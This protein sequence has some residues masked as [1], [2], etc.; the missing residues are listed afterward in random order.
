M[1]LAHEKR[2]VIF[3][4]AESYVKEYRR[5]ER[6]EICLKR[7]ARHHGSFYVPAEPKVAIVVRIRGYVLQSVS[8]TLYI[9]KDI[10]I[11]IT[12]CDF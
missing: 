8:M 6:D 1:Q 11:Y 9:F 5:K 10:L 4:R 2:R 3:K 7:L 12:F